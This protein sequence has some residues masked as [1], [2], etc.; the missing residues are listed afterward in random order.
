MDNELRLT[1]LTALGIDIWVPRVSLSIESY[2]EDNWG[3]LSSDISQCT[4]CDLCDSRT[5]SIIGTGSHQ[6]EWLWITEAPSSIEDQNGQP[7]LGAEGDLFTEML[8]AINLTRED[9]FVTHIIK[10]M[11]PKHRTPQATELL[12]CQ[13]YIERQIKLLQPKIIIALGQIAAHALIDQPMLNNTPVVVINHPAYLL[14]FLSEKNLAWR[15]LQ[16]AFKL[17]TELKDKKCGD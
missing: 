3:K 5:H 4:Q 7:M 10:C 8:R 2:V 6:A 17:Y 9:I 12:S 14:K 11:T 1:Y 13:S 16:Y 15:D